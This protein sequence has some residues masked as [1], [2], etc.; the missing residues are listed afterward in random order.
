MIFILVPPISGLTDLVATIGY[1]IVSVV[2]D[3]LLVPISTYTKLGYLHESQ[4]K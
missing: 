1:T 3:L 4:G 2:G